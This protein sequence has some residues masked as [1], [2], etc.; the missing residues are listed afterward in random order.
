M[1]SSS[2][3]FRHRQHSPPALGHP[4]W[5]SEASI[6]P[7]PPALTSPGLSCISGASVMS[8]GPQRGPEAQAKLTT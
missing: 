6:D 2:F 4:D 7:C 1:F 3:V 5:V 8:P